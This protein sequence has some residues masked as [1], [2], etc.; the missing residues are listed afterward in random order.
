M[1]K[2]I[3]TSC[4]IWSASVKGGNLKKSPSPEI[5]AATQQRRAMMAVEKVKKNRKAS[6]VRIG[7]VVGNS[8]LLALN[9]SLDLQPRKRSAHWIQRD[10]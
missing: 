6:D 3:P 7:K 8:S 10:T 2:L 1:I 4:Q 5:T 9:C